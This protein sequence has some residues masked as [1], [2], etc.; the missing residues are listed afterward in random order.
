MQRLHLLLTV[1]NQISTTVQ[2]GNEDQIDVPV[3]G[4]AGCHQR[5]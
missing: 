4:L 5:K 1:E 2:K 3:L